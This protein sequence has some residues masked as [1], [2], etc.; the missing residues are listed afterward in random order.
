[1]SRTW[2]RWA[3]P[4]V[5]AAILALLLWRL[6]A[7]PFLDGVR[8]IDARSLSVAA[9]ITALTTVCSAWR[10]V[11]MDWAG[12]SVVIPCRK[13]ARKKKKAMAKPTTH[14]KN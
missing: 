11:A 3:R 7:G 5:G 2:W 12:D 14:R 8:T 6:G 9:G 10:S 13:T 1:M 4:L